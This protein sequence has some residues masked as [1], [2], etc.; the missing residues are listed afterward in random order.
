VGI[1][2]R[3]RF[4]FSETLTFVHK[5]F[6]EYAAARYVLS[7]NADERAKVLAEIEPAQQWNEVVVFSSALGLGAD[8]VQIALVRAREGNTDPTRLL[9]WV[10]HSKD[11]LETGLAE[12]VL[13]Q[14]GEVI[15]AAHSGKALSTGVDLVA[16]LDR[17]PGAAVHAQA[18]RGHPQ[19]W[20][21]LV[22]W[23]CFVRVNPELLVFA[24]L[25]EFMA[26]YA[27]GADNRTVSGGFV[28]YDPVSQLWEELVLSSAREAVLRGIGVEEQKF[29]DR[30]SGSL[31][32]HSMG[33]LGDFSFILKEAG[34]S[35]KLPVQ[36]DLISK[37]FS[38]D[39]FEQGRQDMRALFSAIGQDSPEYAALANAPLLHLSAFWY[40]TG[41]MK[42]EMSAATLAA[43]T[44]S[45]NEARQIVKLAARLSSYDYGQLLAEA[46]T[47]I[48]S[49]EGADGLT[50]SFDGLISVDAPIKW[51]G[52]PDSSARPLITKA[53]LHP[54]NWI[55]YLA[56]NL[57][58]HLLNTADAAELV[59]QVLAESNG[60]GMAAAAELAVHFLGK[61]RARE[62]I[63]ERLKQPL[64]TGCQHLY[65]YLVEVWT[66]ELDEQASEILRPALCFGPRT[67]KAALHL[68]RACSEAHRNA[69]IPMLRDVYDYWLKN[70]EPYPIET[71]TIPESPRGEILALLIEKSAVSQEGLFSA[72]KDP[73]S[74]VSEPAKNALLAAFSKSETA[75]NELVRR[76]Q[77]G[78]TLDDLLRAALRSRAP[79][80]GQDV[81]W[82]AGLL[83]SESPQTRSAAADILESQYLLPTEIRKWAEKLLH[84]PYQRLRDRGYERLAAL[85]V[86]LNNEAP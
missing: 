2:E 3:V 33:F 5:T 79:F 46:Q 39:Y 13:Q 57:A 30:V 73:R 1:V 69:L 9:R 8:L 23:V 6:G 76:I 62:L 81:Q 59:P 70:E 14:A 64:N 4:K 42:L 61:D 7:R 54:S 71:G 24:A 47:K 10:K 75:R 38:P 26:S 65:K 16:A 49:L 40:G 51:S 60:W 36:E 53:L 37:Y 15:V 72:V 17:L 48:G 52:N 86:K 63:V 31:N 80:S 85:K 44:S 12:M 77:R 66:P 67:A 55:V 35:I 45:G 34:V 82:I 25:L 11:Q 68:A 18:Y 22:G 84:D 83:Q 28:L 56:A 32:A 21:A 78:E 20:T 50:G 19:W 29:I 27:E 74:D 41:L 58:E 43:K